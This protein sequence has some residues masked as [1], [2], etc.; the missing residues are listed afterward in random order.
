MMK[1]VWGWGETCKKPLSHLGIFH[2][3]NGSGFTVIFLQDIQRVLRDLQIVLW[4][5]KTECKENRSYHIF[6]LMGSY[7]RIVQNRG[8]MSAWGEEQCHLYKHP[9]NL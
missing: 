3:G 8:K 6:K 4:S 7:S 2:L 1:R 5:S 9:L